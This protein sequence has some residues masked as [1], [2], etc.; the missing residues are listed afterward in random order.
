MQSTNRIAF[1]KCWG[2]EI[3]LEVNTA[4][5]LEAAEASLP[6][7]GIEEAKEYVRQQLQSMSIRHVSE[8]ELEAYTQGKSSCFQCLRAVHF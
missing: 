5:E 7:I 4:M 3:N 1:F 2:R 6:E 8:E